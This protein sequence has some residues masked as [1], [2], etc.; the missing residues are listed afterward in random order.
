MPAVPMP[1]LT[2][3]VCGRPVAA[4]SPNWYVYMGALFCFCSESCRDRF[5]AEPARFT[6]VAS[7]GGAVSSSATASTSPAGAIG[8]ESAVEIRQ[9]EG[10]IGGSLFERTPDESKRAAEGIRHRSWAGA[11]TEESAWPPRKA[12]LLAPEPDA[13]G[14]PRAGSATAGPPI[15]S[16]QS[17][18]GGLLATLFAWRER[19][20]AAAVARE[21]LALYRAVS[22]RNPG[23]AGRELYKKILAERNG[24]DLRSAEGQIDGA[25]QSF[26]IW[27]VAQEVKFSD[28]VHYV[29]ASEFMASHGPGRWIQADIKHV[30]TERIPRDL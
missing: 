8:A 13:P 4:A 10:V 28:V 9:E 15:F 25:E 5:A 18:S 21:L 7:G 2:D 20:F 1:E 26:A 6:P 24:G 27:P 12:K 29:A 14:S 19:R 23:L 11:G 30:V 3:A 16:A 17:G 22:A